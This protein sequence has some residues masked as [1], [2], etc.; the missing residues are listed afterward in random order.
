MV[1]VVHLLFG[2]ILHI[3]GHFHLMEVLNQSSE[4]L[5]VKALI[6]QVNQSTE[7]LRITS[8]GQIGM[9][10]ASPTQELGRGLHIRGASGGTRIHLTN[11]DTGDTAT[12]GFYIISQGA[13]S[14]G[15]SGEVMLQQKRIK[16]LNLQLIM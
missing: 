9:G 7:A 14:G 6:F 5:V 3:L 10:I 11:S 15:A 12:D 8:D 16:L 13:E 4:L 1:M 2:E